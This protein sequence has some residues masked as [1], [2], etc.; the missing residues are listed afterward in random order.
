MKRRR[1]K[2]R[3]H[4]GAPALPKERHYADLRHL[5]FLENASKRLQL[6]PLR[7]G[8]ASDA[9][10][11]A[12]KA[13]PFAL[14]LPQALAPNQDRMPKSEKR[15]SSPLAPATCSVLLIV[16]QRISM[17]YG[18]KQKTK[19]VVAAEATALIAWRALQQGNRV[20]A[21]I[22]NDTKIVPFTPN[23]SR[24]EVMVILH[25]LLNQ[26]HLL[27]GRLGRRSNTAMLNTALLRAEKLAPQDHLIV[28]ITDASGHDQQTLRLLESISRHNNLVLSLVYDPR[29]ITL[30]RVGSFIFESHNADDKDLTHSRFNPSRISLTSLSTRGDVTS[31]LRRVFR[32]APRSHRP[33]A[34]QNQAAQISEPDIPQPNG[35]SVVAPDA[36]M[37]TDPSMP[38]PVFSSG[39][40]LSLC[41]SSNCP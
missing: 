40:Q 3:V 27:A 28:L 39:K 31:Q 34:E 38:P 13:G 10:L 35:V 23:C 30:R 33:A 14:E 18:S 37:V 25:T 17:F 19:S 8:P 12:S 2:T 26:N 6:P 5:V 11:A 20:G 15:D 32:K 22:F 41:E 24:L 21:L 16:D 36:A 9:E 7:H 4:K 29:Q 1:I